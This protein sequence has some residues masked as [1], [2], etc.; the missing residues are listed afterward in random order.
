LLSL[1]L[2]SFFPIQ[3]PEAAEWHCELCVCVCPID[4]T[5]VDW[6]LKTDIRKNDCLI[7]VL[8]AENVYFVAT[9]LSTVQE[10][11]YQ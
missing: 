7:T 6:K 1:V 2:F 8:I 10:L 11:V 5:I 3:N 4:L 9:V